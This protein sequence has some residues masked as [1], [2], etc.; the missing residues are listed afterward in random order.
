MYRH[1]AVLVY[2]E[3][4]KVFVGADANTTVLEIGTKYCGM[5]IA[6]VKV[7]GIVVV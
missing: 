5:L 2:E 1:F 7:L 6:C 4:L 3:I